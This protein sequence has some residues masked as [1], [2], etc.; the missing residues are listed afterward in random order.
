MRAAGL[1]LLLL[2]CDAEEGRRPSHPVGYTTTE[3]TTAAEESTGSTGD[4]TTTTTTTGPDMG[5]WTTSGGTS[6]GGPAATGE[7]DTTSTSTTT[8]S[9]A[10]ATGE[11]T[12]STTGTTTGL[13]VVCE[14]SPEMLAAKNVCGA[15]PTPTCEH[16]QP[17]G[18]CDPDGDGV[19][20][21]GDWNAGYFAY[22]EVCG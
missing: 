1:A 7:D 3:G 21:D 11:D 14:C 4:E 15:E 19:Y 2:A 20:E 18:L 22:L 5:D 10:T 6:T 16:T 12:T 8:T 9:D 13:E 17:G